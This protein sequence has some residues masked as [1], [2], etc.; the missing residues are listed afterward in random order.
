MV[1]KIFNDRA[2]N[3]LKLVIQKYIRDG[4]P[5]G[6]K[7][8]AED[9][10]IALSSATIRNIMADLEGAGYLWSPHTSAGRIPTVQGYRFF[11]DSILSA[12][13]LQ[14]LV[15]ENLKDKFPPDAN[16]N[17]LVETASNVLSHI[18][19]LA[20]LVT[21]PKKE[22]F[23]LRQIEFLALSQNRVL[24]IIIYNDREVQNR[25]IHTGKVYSSSELQQAG[26]YLTKTYVGK[27]W[28]EIRQEMFSAVRDAKKNMQNILHQAAEIIEKAFCEDQKNETDFVLAGESNLLMMAE[29]AGIGRLRTLFETLNQKK[30]ILDLLDACQ[31]S[32]GVQIFIGQECGFEVLGDCSIVTAP[33]THENKIL[34][35]LGVIGPT[36]MPYDQVIS[37]VDVTAKLLSAALSDA[38]T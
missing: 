7:V 38:A 18:T 35:V 28:L 31:R 11:V 3:V 10:S 25:I 9:S 22:H 30:I 5:V 1:E 26:N 19:K 32:T 34:G 36:R 12:Q 17:L 33:Y 20:S 21:L 15:I 24:A 29:E 6:S 2:L 23:I 14:N 13:P 8:L 16:S 37:T 27:D 4:Q